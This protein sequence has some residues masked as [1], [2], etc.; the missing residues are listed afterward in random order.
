MARKRTETKKE[1]GLSVK[2]YRHRGVGKWDFHVCK[3]PQMLGKELE[4]LRR[5]FMS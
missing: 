5:N 2:D 1:G 3:D 4:W